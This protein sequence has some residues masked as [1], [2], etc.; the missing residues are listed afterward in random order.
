MASELAGA[1]TPRER[2]AALARVLR[3]QQDYI[4][5]LE[6][7]L[8]SGGGV[9]SG[10]GTVG[11]T[12]ADDGG[13]VN[14]LSAM[15]ARAADL[16][17][18]LTAARAEAANLRGARDAA[19][20]LAHDNAQLQARLTSALAEVDT[21][22]TAQTESRVREER[23]LLAAAA[24]ERDWAARVADAESAAEAARASV[25]TEVEA[26]TQALV[27][28]NAALA[29]AEARAATA[30]ST[31]SARWADGAKVAAEESRS[32]RAQLAKRVADIE[33]LERARAADEERFEA[34]VAERVAAHVEQ[35]RRACDERDRCVASWG[36][37]S[38]V[39]F[40]LSF[41]FL[42][43]YLF[44]QACMILFCRWVLYG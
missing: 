44:I 32:L 14:S 29:E 34:Q 8:S 10:G 33:T 13:G 17:A 16:T 4:A 7:R 20:T 42:F 3:A 9:S 15:R 2:D 21:L 35:F 23:R 1:A 27:K 30:E 6:A 40:C 31:V 25:V 43:V 41:F 36:S 12:G 26:L 24:R 5:Q 18:A 39:F 38:F 28:C 11:A 37:L 19:G 22:R